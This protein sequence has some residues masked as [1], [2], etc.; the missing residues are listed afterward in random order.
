[1][2]AIRFQELIWE[3]K[4]INISD[5]F[6]LQIVTKLNKR[7]RIYIHCHKENK[8]SLID[9]GHIFQ[10]TL[11]KSSVNNECPASGPNEQ[12]LGTITSSQYS[13]S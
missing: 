1:M 7:G 5:M 9:L 13:A 3:Q 11:K 6:R 4:K 10:Y 8:N 2:E 12:A